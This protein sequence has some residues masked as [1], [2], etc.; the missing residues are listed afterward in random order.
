MAKKAPK[1]KPKQL[2]KKPSKAIKV[3]KEELKPSIE[4]ISDVKSFDLVKNS[5]VPIVQY[6]FLKNEK[7]LA[8][9]IKKIGFPC[10]LKVSGTKIIH[11][12]EFKGVRTNIKSEEEALKN[13]RELMKI[14]N[15]EGVLLQKQGSG[16]EIIV[17]IKQDPQFQHVVMFGL[18]GI[19]VEKLNDVSFRVCPLTPEDAKAMIRE[20]KGYDLLAGYRGKPINFIALEDLLI[21][22]SRLAVKERIAEMDLNPVFCDEKG[23]YVADVR[24]IKR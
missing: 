23:C 19:W 10:V 21:K 4:R 7:N 13:F 17:G 8:D 12:T 2:K 18:G 16:V 24:I 5:R 11:R 15:A 3:K 6:F 14:K 22:V 9:S 1:K 20:I